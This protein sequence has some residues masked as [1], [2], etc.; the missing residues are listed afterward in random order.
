MLGLKSEYA[1]PLVHSYDCLRCLPRIYWP[2]SIPRRPGLK[3][4]ARAYSLTIVACL[5][6]TLFCLIYPIYVIRPF[7]GQGVRELAAALLVIRF[8]P[9][10]DGLCVVLAVVA[11]ARYWPLQSRR[12][13]RAGTAA[14]TLG[15]CAFGALSLVN[16]YELM[17][18]P[19]NAPAVEAAADSKLDKNEM[20]IAVRINGASRA[21]PIRSISYHHIVNDTVGGL[22]VVATY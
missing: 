12:W 9:F 4:S 6:V 19:I 21:Y 5:A 18:H 2:H 20:V 11:L 16:V 10:V 13:R 15:V 8:R 3:L 17:F 14:A 22:P 7:R 1:L